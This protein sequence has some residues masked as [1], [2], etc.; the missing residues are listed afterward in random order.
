MLNYGHAIEAALLD[1]KEKGV[2]VLLA[3]EVPAQGLVFG[4]GTAAKVVCRIVSFLSLQGALF[5]AG[6]LDQPQ[7]VELLEPEALR[8]GQRQGRSFLGRLQ[9]ALA[10]R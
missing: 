3:E 1:G 9:P 4:L 7:V 10:N 5:T 2:P 8:R 6:K